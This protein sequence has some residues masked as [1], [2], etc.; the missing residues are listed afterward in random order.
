MLFLFAVLPFLS[1]TLGGFAGSHAEYVRVPAANLLGQEGA[2]G[3]RAAGVVAAVGLGGETL[4]E[5]ARSALVAED[6]DL[7][8]IG[9]QDRVIDARRVDLP[10]QVVDA[11]RRKEAEWTARRQQLSDKVRALCGG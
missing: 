6:A 1:T 8:E 3:Q 5:R 11:E 4:G 2:E 10:A 9:A 7:A